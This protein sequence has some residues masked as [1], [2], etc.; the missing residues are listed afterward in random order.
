METRRDENGA[1]RQA[2]ADLANAVPLDEDVRCG[3]R[4]RRQGLRGAKRDAV[5]L[6]LRGHGR[7]PLDQ[8]HAEGDHHRATRSACAAPGCPDTWLVNAAI[9]PWRPD[10]AFRGPGAGCGSRGVRAASAR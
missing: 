2:R 1:V 10:G 3:S 6:T 8:Y 9:M 5:S 7:G 4:P